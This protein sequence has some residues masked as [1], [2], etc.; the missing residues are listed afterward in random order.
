MIKTGIIYLSCAVR[1]IFSVNL[2]NIIKQIKLKWRKLNILVSS[3]Q[4][5]IELARYGR[6]NGV[7]YNSNHR[8][9]FVHHR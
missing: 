6:R 9:K 3:F 7:S 5:G 4:W 2:K 8:I 1:D